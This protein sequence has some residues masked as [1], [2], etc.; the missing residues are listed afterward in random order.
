MLMSLIIIQQT[1]S[2]SAARV[3]GMGKNLTR[4]VNL[5]EENVEEINQYGF[6]SEKLLKKSG[7]RG[8]FQTGVDNVLFTNPNKDKNQS[9]PYVKLEVFPFEE[10]NMYIDAKMAYRFDYNKDHGVERVPIKSQG[11]SDF[12]NIWGQTNAVYTDF[13]IG[14]IYQNGDFFINYKVGY[15]NFNFQNTKLAYRREYRFVPKASY[16][17]TETLRWYLKGYLGYVEA[18]EKGQKVSQK[19]KIHRGYIHKAE[20]GFTYSISESLALSLGAVS[21][22]EEIYAG[23]HVEWLYLGK[24]DYNLYS[25][26]N[27][28]IRPF[29]WYMYAPEGRSGLNKSVPDKF[30]DEPGYKLG[31]FINYEFAEVLALETDISWNRMKRNS[32]S[33]AGNQGGGNNQNSSKPK[34]EFQDAFVVRVGL[35]YYF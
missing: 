10:S 18:K 6:E 20:S 30:K 25:T 35:K 14:S 3:P 27:I 2:A 32:N 15:D 11:V 26:E 34:R 33:G 17:I 5:A 29:F 7:A 12:Q 4:K 9:Y 22:T 23:E 28:Q 31:T 24:I 16:T 8:Y 1:A 21:R 13:N 19:S